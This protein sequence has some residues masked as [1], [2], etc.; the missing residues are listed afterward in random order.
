MPR[1]P[2]PL[3]GSRRRQELE[4][5]LAAAEH[6]LRTWEPVWTDFL[7]GALL[8]EARARLE[9][10]GELVI[11][12]Q[13]GYPG[14]ERCRLLLLRQEIAASA[15]VSAEPLPVDPLAAE[16]LPT[17]EAAAR[18]DFAGL[19]VAGNFL[20]DPAE[21]ADFRQAL[22]A[23]GAREGEL[24]DLW[25]RG[26]R[27]AQLIGAASLAQRLDGQSGTVRSVAVRFEAR[28]REQLSLPVRPQ[29]RSL[30]TVE[31]ST[32]LDAVAS[33]GFGLSRNR[34]AALIRQGAV[35]IGWEPVL[36]PS[37]MVAVG[38]RLRLEGRG[39]L[40][41]QEI[42]TTKRERWRIRLERR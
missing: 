32:R 24:G 2:D 5:L 34:M 40:W 39:E 29:P 19:E 30:T 18:G 11:T 1:P 17:E 12:S 8:E 3:A 9:P 28:P 42:E 31:A 13:G 23:A 27:G 16:P 36:S 25:L 22:L 21:G 20:F 38:D 26:D 35:R 10:L 4:P 15:A 41:I 33:A 14:A 37:R 6:C 7:D